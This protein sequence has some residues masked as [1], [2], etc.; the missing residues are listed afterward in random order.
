LSHILCRIVLVKLKT[1]S[2]N[3]VESV[4]GHLLLDLRKLQGKISHLNQFLADL[5]HSSY[6][7][8]APGPGHVRELPEIDF[9]SEPFRHPDA[10]FYQILKQQLK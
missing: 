9:Q 3:L 6:A 7:L 4:D 2:S 5:S 10:T 8:H 1:N